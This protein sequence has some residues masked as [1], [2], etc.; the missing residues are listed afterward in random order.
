M[1]VYVGKRRPRRRAK[2]IQTETSN[3]VCSH[4]TG[5]E[6][7][8]GNAIQRWNFLP[9]ATT[10]GKQ[11]ARG[12]VGVRP[13]SRYVPLPY[14]GVDCLPAPSTSR[15]SVCCRSLVHHTVTRPGNLNASTPLDN[16]ARHWIIPVVRI[17]FRQLQVS[18]ISNGTMHIPWTNIGRDWAR[19]NGRWWRNR[20][21]TTTEHGRSLG[22]RYSASGV[23]VCYMYCLHASVLLI[24]RKIASISSLGLYC[25]IGSGMFNM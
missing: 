12:E 4:Q 8:L 7:A 23:W 9:F 16:L 20:A 18:F 14:V 6:T 1:A 2:R 10:A 3:S 15:L 25:T 21:E 5:T 13:N 24:L 17:H 11:E 19:N 22:A